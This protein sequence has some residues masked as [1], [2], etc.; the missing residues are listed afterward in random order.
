MPVHD[1]V[2][3]RKAHCGCKL[4]YADGGGDIEILAFHGKR[5]L[6]F[7]I[8]ALADDQ[9]LTVE[10]LEV[11]DVPRLQAIS[12]GGSG[13]GEYRYQTNAPNM[14]VTIFTTFLPLK[15]APPWDLYRFRKAS[16]TAST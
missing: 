10:N 16:E 5:H 14:I 9:R 1:R 3:R 8:R 15:N 6:V 13:H 2:T 11:L 12:V 7:V 4:L